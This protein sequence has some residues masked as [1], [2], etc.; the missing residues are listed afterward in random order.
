MAETCRHI[1]KGVPLCFTVLL[2]CSSNV[3]KGCACVF[4]ILARFFPHRAV[5]RLL[6]QPAVA[7]RAKLHPINTVR[8]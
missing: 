6:I 1:M 2:P 4:C 5:E 8:P 7:P 3:L